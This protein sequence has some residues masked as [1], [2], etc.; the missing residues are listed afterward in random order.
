[1]IKNPVF[2]LIKTVSVFFPIFCRNSRGK[3]INDISYRL[4]IALSVSRIFIFRVRYP[5]FVLCHVGVQNFPKGRI[6]AKEIE[7]KIKE[8]LKVE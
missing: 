2:S 7:A 8:L 1:M 3:W 5:L 6:S 4:R